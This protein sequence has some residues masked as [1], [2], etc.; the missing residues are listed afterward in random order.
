M[1]QIGIQIQMN[2]LHLSVNK[3]PPNE[4][5]CKDEVVNTAGGSDDKSKW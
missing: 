3:L 2:I 1:K 5:I 4:E